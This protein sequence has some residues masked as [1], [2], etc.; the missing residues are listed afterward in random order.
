MRGSLR[1]HLVAL[2][3]GQRIELACHENQH[4]ELVT[5]DFLSFEDGR[6]L[7]ITLNCW[8]S[9]D[10][11]FGTCRCQSHPVWTTKRINRKEMLS[12]LRQHLREEKEDEARR[13]TELAWLEEQISSLPD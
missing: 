8:S 3:R 7:R 4:G 11:G 5:T 12:F 13:E 9:A 1:E 6:W 10:V 2:H